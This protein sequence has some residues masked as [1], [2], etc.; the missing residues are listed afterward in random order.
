M[1]EL[2][3]ASHRTTESNTST[4][5]PKEASTKGEGKGK[6]KGKKDLL[7]AE[8]GVNPSGTRRSGMICF[9]QDTANKL[10][11]DAKDRSC[12]NVHLDTRIAEESVRFNRAK[13]SYSAKAAKKSSP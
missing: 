11:C 7:A 8:S 3:L 6:L 9:K 12:P 5:A 13:S 2:Q 4:S 1:S 10:F